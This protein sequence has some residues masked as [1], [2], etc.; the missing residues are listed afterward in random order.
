MRRIDL[1][2]FS[3]AQHPVAKHA[4]FFCPRSFTLRSKQDLITVQT[5]SLHREVES[6]RIEILCYS[7]RQHA[8]DHCHRIFRAFG[9]R[10][11]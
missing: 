5:L 8:L 10:A 4:G 11:F 6:K 1:A 2:N 7:A 3:A 9:A